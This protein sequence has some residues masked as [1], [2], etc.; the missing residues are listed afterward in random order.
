[1]PYLFLICLLVSGVVYTHGYIGTNRRYLSAPSFTSAVPSLARTLSHQPK[2]VLFSTVSN[3]SAPNKPIKNKLLLRWITGLSL[4][5]L[6]TLWII[7]GNSAFTFGFFITSCIAQSEYYGILKAK[8]IMP[9]SKIG[10]FSTVICYIAA[11][12]MP[13]YHELMMPLS[14]TA[15]MTWLLVFNKKIASI[16]EI[17][18]S[19]LGMYYVGYLPSFWVRL[20]AIEALP[21]TQIPYMFVE[22]NRKFPDIFSLGALITWITWT[23]IVV[24]DVAAYFVGKNF[25]KNKLSTVSLA[26]GSA[27][28]NKTVEGALGGFSFCVLFCIL[29]AYLLDWPK[30]VL[31]GSLY[32][33]LVSFVALVG[34]LTA[35]MMKRDAGVKDTGNILPG[36][37]GLLDRIDS[38]MLTAPACYFFIT[39]VLPIINKISS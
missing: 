20:R 2:N 4:G 17:S 29:G 11:A 35:S 28:P 22:L 24:A 32:G 27:S 30:F 23:S 10:T 33:L 15:L 37:G 34:D 36:H 3:V 38:Y 26:A 6:G 25:G 21:N 1:M 16:S 13:Q 12:F 39:T 7:S 31:S 8:G 14:V 19:L 9:A 5:A 18:S